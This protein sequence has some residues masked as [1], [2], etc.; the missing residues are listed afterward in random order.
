[1]RILCL[2]SGWQTPSSRF[3]VLQYLPHLRRLGHTCHVAPSRPAKY[4][5][6]RWLGW[7]GSE[8]LRRA[9]RVVDV[10]RA[11]FG[12]YDA[13]LVE[14]E[15]FDDDQSW[16]E[17]ALRRVA[18]RLVLDVDDA[19][20]QLHPRKFERIVPWFDT[21]VAG[22]EGLAEWMR[23]RNPRTVVIPTCVDLGQYAVKRAESPERPVIGWMGTRSNLRH[24][25]LVAEPLRRL[26][27][28]NDFELRIVTNADLTPLTI[29]QEA[30]WQA[31]DF[32][33][34]P[35]SAE[36]EV[37]SLRGFDV[38]LMPL[39]DDPWTRGKCGLKAIQYLAVGV[40]AVV[41]PV[42]VNRQIVPDGECGYWAETSEQWFG[43]LSDLLDDPQLRARLGGAGRAHVERQ[44]SV[45]SQ[46]DRWIAAVSGRLTPERP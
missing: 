40:P 24:L 26:A 42:G 19:V 44:Y 37:E 31:I 46:L 18:E 36:S 4:E 34:V 6:Y 13:V 29:R 20:F 25:A 41:S 3:R 1:M 8:A 5:R 7:R 17:H 2:I 35:W 45:A 30:G 14:R 39:V 33:A 11:A 43:R 27:E 28:R 21:I 16:G 38:G 9:K 10:W 22:N 12:R 32:R 15:L 23:P